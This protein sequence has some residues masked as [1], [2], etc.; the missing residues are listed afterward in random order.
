MLIIFVALLEWE[1]RTSR[2]SAMFFHSL[3]SQLTFSL[4]DGETPVRYIPSHGPYDKRLGYDRIPELTASLKTQGYVVS[5]QARLSPAH[6]AYAHSGFYPIY[7]EKSQ[8]GLD[9]HDANGDS[10]FAARIPENAYPSFESIPNLVVRTLLFIEDQK[11]LSQHLPYRNPA[12][13]WNRLIRAVW[14]KGTSLLLRDR[15]VPGG[16]TLATQMEKFKH[17]P[18]GITKEPGDKFKQMVSASLRSFQDSEITLDRRKQIV[19][20]YINGVPSG[21]KAGFGEVIGLS[22][23]LKAWY[24]SDFA[25][26]NRLL[27][28]APKD[29]QPVDPIAKARAYKQVLSLFLAHRRPTLYLQTNPQALADLTERYINALSKNKIISP[30]FAADVRLATIKISADDFKAK[31]NET[32]FL[33]RKSANAIRLPLLS[34]L[35]LKN[36]YELD[37]LDMRVDSSINQKAQREVTRILAEL[38]NPALAEGLGLRQP[39]LLEKGDPSKVHYSFV[40]MERSEGKNL[41]RVQ[42]DSLDAPFNLNESG[43]LELGST[44]KLRV[45]V[46]YLQIIE[47]LHGELS[48]LPADDLKKLDKRDPLSNWVRDELLASPGT[49]LEALL[50]KSLGRHYSA[51]PY[52]TFIS[53][54]ASHRFS[55]YNK[56]DDGSWPT[57]L[58]AFT[59]SMNLPFV[60]ILRDIVDYHIHGSPGYPEVIKDASHARRKPL[61]TKF[62][63]HESQLFLLRPYRKYRGKTLSESL[64]LLAPSLKKSPRAFAVAFRS[65][66]PEGSMEDMQNFIEK[67]LTKTLQRNLTYQKLYEQ[68]DPSRPELTLHDRGY[69]AGVHPLDLWMI[70]YYQK[71][72]TA[73]WGKVLQE[74]LEARLSVY[75]WL[76]EAK[77]K[78]IQ[79]GRI[80]TMLEEEAFAAIGASWRK[81]GFPFATVV[82]TLATALGSSGDRPSALAELIGIIQADGI[83]SD[84]E[85]VLGIHLAEGTP[86]ETQLVKTS[87]APVR[88]LSHEVATTV[89]GAL[90][91]VVEEGTA[92]R[93]KDLL[94]VPDCGNIRI[95][96]KT[97]TGDNRYEVAAANGESQS[98]RVINRTAT[99]VFSMGERY[100]GTLTAY[101]PSDAAAAYG[102]TSAL[103]VQVLKIIAP[104]IMP[105]PLGFE[106]C[107]E[108]VLSNQVTPLIPAQ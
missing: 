63:D 19:V 65:V 96:G 60:R 77:N 38:R 46:S 30:E 3:A 105:E 86:Y 11:L 47:G 103:P 45:L 90:F 81:L 17:S 21:A 54:G 13:E 57:I 50:Q 88:L 6:L 35:G 34:Q 5:Q 10:L 74:S 29:S 95:G 39:H 25:E 14:Q 69:I 84:T 22:S 44:A 24:G 76:T 87:E 70:A 51:S 55:N 91:N 28:D 73:D 64:D 66:N 58:Q 56:D 7:D 102:F 52:E 89:Q 40:L 1:T 59:K 61:L 82:P 48:Q 37:R 100:F 18:D 106:N 12:V 53:G 67:H 72:S 49:G 36:L 2:L 104:R 94:K 68:A 9:I 32:S 80:R 43:K 93:V 16:S 75:R 108:K 33:E 83:R 27:A 8:A 78:S 92:R 107:Q 101:V 31:N 26:V 79:D 41:L 97:G 20:D 98:S 85:R 15:S 4:V 23:G 62:A 71:F 99:F 42:T